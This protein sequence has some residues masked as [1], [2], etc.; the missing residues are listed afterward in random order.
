MYF[1]G[2]GVRKDQSEAQRWLVVEHYN[3]KHRASS[4][5]KG[6]LTK[7]LTAEQVDSTVDLMKSTYGLTYRNYQRYYTQ[8]SDHPPS[9]NLEG[10]DYDQYNVVFGYFDS[11]PAQ[12]RAVYLAIPHNLGEPYEAGQVHIGS[13]GVVPMSTGGGCSVVT[14]I[15]FVASQT[16]EGPQ[17]N[18]WLG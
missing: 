17:C 18:S 6:S 3:I 9:I 12:V 7:A 8:F 10:I 16:F 5:S 2:E 14:V 1:S 11:M 4:F 15:Y 13:E